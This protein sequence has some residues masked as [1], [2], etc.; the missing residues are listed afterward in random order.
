MLHTHTSLNLT[1]PAAVQANLNLLLFTDIMIFI[2][3]GFVAALG[4]ARLLGSFSQQHLL[5]SWVCVTFCEFWQYFTLFHYPLWRW[6]EITDIWCYCCNCFGVPHT[7]QAALV[8]KKLPA[9]AGD[10]RYRSD[11]WVGKILWR[12][13]WQP[14]PVFLP[15]ESR[16]QRSLAGYSPW[17]C[18]RVRHKWVT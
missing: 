18:K 16:G 3:W 11:P 2:N 7:S 9:N 15:G 13:A 17:G 6:S 4:W 5:T 8:V 14:T 10:R 1:P 12:R